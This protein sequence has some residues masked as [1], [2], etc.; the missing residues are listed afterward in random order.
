MRLRGPRASLAAIYLLAL[1]WGSMLFYPL[2]YATQGYISSTGNLLA[3]AGF[4][5]LTNLA[6]VAFASTA[7]RPT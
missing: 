7:L 4:Q 5:G 3:L 6:A 1:L 2:H